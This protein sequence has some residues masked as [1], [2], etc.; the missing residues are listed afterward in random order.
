MPTIET[1]HIDDVYQLEDEYGNSFATR[2][3]TTPENIAYVEELARSMQP[4]GI[5]D[6]MVTLVRD[7]GIYRIKSG[8][9][10][11]EAMRKLGTKTF[12]A[13]VEDETTEQAILETV[14]RTN[15][16]KK[17]SAT[18]ESTFIRQLCLF[19]DDEYVSEVSGVEREKVAKVRRATRVIDDAANDMSLGRLCAI[20]EFEKYPDVVEALTNCSEKEYPSIVKQAR[21]AI[22]AAACEKLLLRGFDALRIPI[23]QDATGLVVAAVS[24]PSDLATVRRDNNPCDIVAKK[25]EFAG[26]YNIIDVR[27]PEQNTPNA[28]ALDKMFDGGITNRR[29]WLAEALKK[30]AKLTY[31]RA[32]VGK[33]QERHPFIIRPFINATGMTLDIGQTDIVYW[34]ELAN[35]RIRGANLIAEND[36]LRRDACEMYASLIATLHADGYQPTT[37]EMQLLEIAKG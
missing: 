21:E 32:A 9:S 20:A 3:Y 10:R 13:I 18:E 37:H 4:K 14:V 31:I 19:G 11:V 16:K 7:G 34:F 36:E 27:H 17:Y 22:E 5:P 30:R 26:I 1:V 15:T 2:D 35:S 29:A 25:T 24:Q 12:P 8:N 6:E 28:A 33:N 23:D